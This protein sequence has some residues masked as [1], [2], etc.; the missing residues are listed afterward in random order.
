MSDHEIF[1]PFPAPLER[2][3]TV[4]EIRSTLL[5]SSLQAL[6]TRGLLERYTAL[7]PIEHH[8]TILHCIAAQSRVPSE[9]TALHV[10]WV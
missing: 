10:S 4:T 9:M 7:L 1:L 6:K 5:A 8:Q 2:L 3:E